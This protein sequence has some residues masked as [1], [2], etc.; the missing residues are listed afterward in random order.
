MKEKKK[1]SDEDLIPT[2]QKVREFFEGKFVTIL[3][4]AVTIFA[5]FGDDFRLWFTTKKADVWIDGAL[6][7]SLV[8]FTVEIL[9]NSCVVDEF[10]YSFFFWLDIIATVSICVDVKILADQ[11]TVMFGMEPESGDA[12]VGE[13]ASQEAGN[14][15]VGKIIKALRLIRLIRI[16]KLYKYVVKSGSEIEEMRLREQEKKSTNV[17]QA[18]LNRELEP[19]RLGRSLSEALTRRLIILVLVLLMALPAITYSSFDVSHAYGIRQ[20]FWFGRSNCITIDA[21]FDCEEEQWMSLEGWNEHL[22]NFVSAAS[23]GETEDRVVEVLWI[24]SADF[25]RGGVIGDIKNVTKRE[26]EH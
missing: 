17:Q 4:A 20:L 14:N 21:Q 5:L 26:T 19:S 23:P 15:K 11:I 9:V 7:F 10:K 12:I 18:A 16:I 8:A 25:S 13:P 2:R 24:S 3:M 6:I 1:V 22:R